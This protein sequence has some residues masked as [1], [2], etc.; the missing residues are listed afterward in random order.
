MK[1]VIIICLFFLFTARVVAQEETS[2][3]IL[4]G[5]NGGMMIH[6]GYLC[7]ELSG[8]DFRAAGS[9][10]GLGGVARVALGKHWMVGTEG[11]VST[12]YQLHNGSYIKYG[13]GGLLG[14]FYWTFPKVA[15]Y[16][17]ITIGGGKC[18]SLLLLDGDAGD[19]QVELQA[20]FHKEPFM[21]ITPFVGC[22]FILSEAIH[23]TLKLDC[24]NS[25]AH[26]RL[27]MPMGPR[28]YFGIIFYH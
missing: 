12:L 13:W 20:I 19:W 15:P 21:A 1:K 17:G 26:R 8:A 28:L 10:F 22:D 9:P 25:I 6:T 11:Y 7:G 2:T 23:L 3:S 14:Q 27:L 4:T 18:S 16:V 24:L 5:F